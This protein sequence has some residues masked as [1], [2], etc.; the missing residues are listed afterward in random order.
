METHCAGVVQ[1]GGVEGAAYGLI[2]TEAECHIGH[3]T[4]DLAAGTQPL[5]LARRLDEVH[6]IVVVLR[7]T[8]TNCED[9]GVEDDVLG[10]EA[11]L[12]DQNLV[13]TSADAYLREEGGHLYTLLD[14]LVHDLE[15]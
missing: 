6:S 13:G 15:S 11:Y 4:A 3:T 8:G 5:D 12:L 2:A 10:I 9:V 7:Q 14:Y 1:E